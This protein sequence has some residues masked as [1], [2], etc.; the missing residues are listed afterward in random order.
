MDKIREYIDFM[1][2]MSNDMGELI[3]K[4]D[5]CKERLSDAYFGNKE[6]IK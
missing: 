1:Y 4:L 3:N 6:V 5:Q 2:I